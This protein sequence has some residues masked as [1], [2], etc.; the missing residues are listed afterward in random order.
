M[1]FVTLSAI[2]ERVLPRFRSWSVR[3]FLD[4]TELDKIRREMLSL[5]EFY[6]EILE[7]IFGTCCGSQMIPQAFTSLMF[8]E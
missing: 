1:I 4:M 7:F 3:I 2:S 6:F 8:L 5:P